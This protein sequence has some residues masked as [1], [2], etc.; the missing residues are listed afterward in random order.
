MLTVPPAPRV[1]LRYATVPDGLDPTALFGVARRQ[2]PRRSALFVSRV[3]GKHVPVDPAICLFAGLHL[4][5]KLGAPPEASPS[6]TGGM[7]NPCAA[8]AAVGAALAGLRSPGP[9]LVGLRSSDAPLHVIG[10]AETATALGHVVRDGLP[11]ADYVH[12]TRRVE[13]GWPPVVAFSEEHSHAVH[14]RIV[15][16]YPAYLLDDHPVLLVDDELTTGRTLR[17]AIAAIHARSPRAHYLVASFLDWRDDAALAAFDQMEA[18]IG[19]TITVTSLVT[20][21]ASWADDSGYEVPSGEQPAVGVVSPVRDG[22]VPVL[23]H[24]VD[25]GLSV[26]R[27]GWDG[28]DQAAFEGRVPEVARTLTQARR[29]PHAL[30]L[31]TEEFMYA[32]LRVAMAMGDGVMY[33]S[34]T[35]SPILVAD[36]DGYPIRHKA[37]FRNPAASRLASFVYNVAPGAYDDIFVLFEER[38]GETE[39]EPM[40]DALSVARPRALHLVFVRP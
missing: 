35:R 29:G 2:N 31:G 12:T 17:N 26:S 37:T 1:D 28:A 33:Q 18:R 16:R 20:G 9:A 27:H 6:L 24:D 23:R 39:L 14:H 30:V 5:W 10:C 15:H 13:A 22:P 3:L 19:T 25:F 36:V 34:T 40:V 11:G 32:P 4:A 8:R 21:E 38:Y 7:A